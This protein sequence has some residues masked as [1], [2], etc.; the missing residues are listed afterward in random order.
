MVKSVLIFVCVLAMS[1]CVEKI[2]PEENTER[3]KLI[4]SIELY[5]FSLILFILCFYKHYVAIKLFTSILLAAIV[6]VVV[7]Y[8]NVFQVKNKLIKKA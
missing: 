2:F 6:W 4:D 5:G 8:K 1:Y 7:N 3:E